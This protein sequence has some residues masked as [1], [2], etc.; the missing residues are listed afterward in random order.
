MGRRM[1]E[2]ASLT[3]DASSGGGGTL[4]TGRRGVARGARVEG[5]VKR[6]G[7]WTNQREGKCSLGRVHNVIIL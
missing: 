6:R 4:L 3:D 7:E 1:F 2:D 5:E